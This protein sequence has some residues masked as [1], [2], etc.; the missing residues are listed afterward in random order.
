MFTDYC[1]L[2]E[3]SPNA[4][5]ETIDALPPSSPCAG[6]SSC[7]IR[8][9]AR[10][11]LSRTSEK[12]TRRER[13]WHAP[14]RISELNPRLAQEGFAPGSVVGLDLVMNLG[15]IATFASNE[16]DASGGQYCHRRGVW[17][18]GSCHVHRGGRSWRG[19]EAFQAAKVPIEYG[20]DLC[21]RGVRRALVR[22]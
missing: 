4:N 8:S 22:G 5:S 11:P 10:H 18:D 1:E 3:I 17:N 20:P 19:P 15:W 13:R 7:A 9:F 21:Q 14:A 12:V 2:L 16:R 6:S